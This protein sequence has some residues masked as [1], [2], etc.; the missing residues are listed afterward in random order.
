[1]KTEGL[2]SIL[3]TSDQ[4]DLFTV[5]DDEY[6]TTQNTLSG[7]ESVCMIGQKIIRDFFDFMVTAVCNYD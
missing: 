6:N 1:M 4:T 2:K 7:I 5:L 3:S